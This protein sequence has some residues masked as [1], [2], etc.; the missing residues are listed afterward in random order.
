MTEQTPKFFTFTQK[1]VANSAL[2][3]SSGA[4]IGAT[5]GTVIM[6][7][8]GT[9]VGGLVGGLAGLIIERVVDRKP[10]VTQRSE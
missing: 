5:T 6:A 3:V 9:V 4:T 7:G 2:Y 8:V 10:S 1:D